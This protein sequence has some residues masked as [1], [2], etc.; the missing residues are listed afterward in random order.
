MSGVTSYGIH[1]EIEKCIEGMVRLSDLR[2]DF[3]VLDREKHREVGNNTGKVISLGDK[4]KI[5]V[6]NAS[7]ESKEID[8]MLIEE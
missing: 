5:E 8:F 6:L 1:I 3:Y 7:K 2:G 4:V